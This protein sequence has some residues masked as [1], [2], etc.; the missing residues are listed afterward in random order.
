MIRCYN[1]FV[2]TLLASG[3]SMGGI[4]PD[5]IYAVILWDLSRWIR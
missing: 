4:N 3:F 1:D 2:E 5:G